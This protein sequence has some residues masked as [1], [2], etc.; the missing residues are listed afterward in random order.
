MSG[1]NSKISHYRLRGTGRHPAEVKVSGAG[2]FWRNDEKPIW[3]S[4]KVSDETVIEFESESI[5]CVCLPVQSQERMLETG[6]LV[7]TDKDRRISE[8]EGL[9]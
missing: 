2:K 8:T 9:T 5:F 6:L 3:E 1:S 7:L 4:P